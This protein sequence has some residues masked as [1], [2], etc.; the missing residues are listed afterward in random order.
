[1]IKDD[2]YFVVQGWMINRLGLKGNALNVFAIIYGFSQD[3]QS[4][5]DGSASYLAAFCGISRVSV[6]K[7]L[8]DLTEKGVITKT[9]HYHGK[10][11]FCSYT[12]CKKNDTPV[13]KLDTTGKESLLG[14]KESLPQSGKETLHNNILNKLD[15]NTTNNNIPKKQKPVKHRYGEYHHVLLSD[16]Q[17]N[18]LLDEWGKAEL[19]R[20]IKKLDEK[21][22]EKGYKYKNFYI[23]LKNWKSR[24]YDSRYTQYGGVR[25]NSNGYQLPDLSDIPAE[26]M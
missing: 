2:S 13:K 24:N 25:D 18:K 12:A 21:I 26:M 19:E 17:Y 14:G 7:I 3:G 6:L 4:E 8:A 9:E 16:E 11:K 10:I 22:E 15:Y 23:T 5:F 20:W 1:M